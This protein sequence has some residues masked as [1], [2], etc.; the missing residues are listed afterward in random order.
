MKITIF[1]LLLVFALENKAAVTDL[2]CED[3]HRLSCAPGVYDD[4]TGSAQNPT[5]GRNATE[6]ITQDIFDKSKSKFKASILDP[7][8]TYFRKILLS[9]SGLS[10]NS[11]CDGAEVKPKSDCADLMAEAAANISVRRMTAG[12]YS[13]LQSDSRGRLS[14]ETFLAESET[15]RNVEND[16]LEK[17]RNEP[18][19]KEVD[20]RVRENVFPKVKALLLKKVDEMIADPNLKKKLVDKITAIKYEGTNCSKELTGSENLTGTLI[21]NAFYHPTK[22]NFKYCAGLSLQNKSDF[23]MAS[24]I[25]H[26]LGH[27]IDPC[28]IT[29][30]PQDFSFKYTENLNRAQ[31]QEEF[32]FAGVLQCLRSRKS[33]HA[34]F[35][36]VGMQPQNTGSGMQPQTPNA[37]DPAL[38]EPE[39][40]KVFK[41]FC[42]Q[43]QITESFADWISAEML[44]DYL[45]SNYPNLTKDQF[46]SGYSNVWRGA[47]RNGSEDSTGFTDP[48]PSQER[49]IN[50]LLLQQ[51]KIRAQMGCPPS[52]PAGDKVYC[53]LGGV[54]SKTSTAKPPAPASTNDV[55]PKIN[56]RDAR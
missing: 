32:P 15:Y 48:H 13:G 39:K 18:A 10:L 52:S 41:S 26:E 34:I 8:N 28:G 38:D 14:D 12:A 4:G 42:V 40:A 31:A 29:R 43:D 36:T 7:Q 53:P 37:D 35:G 5:F 9:A 3:L 25:G 49:R 11:I 54:Q 23:Q 56:P 51:P 47:C 16:L 45:A 33:V 55:K 50:N 17:V 46:R 27:S 1:L 44:P 22:N 2:V 6:K 24:I 21:T 19:M 20:K 30:G